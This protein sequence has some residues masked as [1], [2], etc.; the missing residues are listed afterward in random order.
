MAYVISNI[1]GAETN[2][3]DE[4]ESWTGT[5]TVEAGGVGGNYFYRIT[6]TANYIKLGVKSAGGGISQNSFGLWFRSSTA[7]PAALTR[8]LQF[9]NSGGTAQCYLQIKTDGKI[10]LSDASANVTTSQSAITVDTWHFIEVA[11]TG[12]LATIFLD[13]VQGTTPGSWSATAID[14]CFLQA[15]TGSYTFDFDNLFF[16]TGTTALSDRLGGSEIISYR[17]NLN[18]ATPDTGTVLNTGTWLQAQQ[19]PFNETPT[20]AYTGS[21]T[22]AGS[23]LTNDVGG[24]AGTGGPSTDTNIT[25]SILAA[26]GVW[27]A[28]RGGGSTTSHYG[29]LGNSADDTTP[30]ANLGLTTLIKNYY[31]LSELSTIVPIASEVGKIGIE[32]NTGGQ[33]FLLADMLFT[34]LHVPAVPI[35]V[36]PS[37]LEATA[38]V[39]SVT[40]AVFQTVL[41]T[42]LGATAGVGNVTVI[43]GAGQTVIPGPEEINT[44]YFDASDEGPTDTSEDWTDD[45]NAFDGSTATA[46]TTIE[47]G[48]LGLD[49][50]GTT[51]PTSGDVILGVKARHYGSVIAGGGVQLETKIYTNG[52]AELLGTY[53]EA[54]TYSPSWRSYFQLAVPS[55]GWT[56]QKANDLEVNLFADVDGGGTATISKVEID[57]TSKGAL[58]IGATGEVG[59]VTVDIAAGAVNV[60]VSGV[61]STG[62]VGSVTVGAGANISAAPPLQLGYFDASISGPTDAEGNWSN[63]A[64]AFDND[65]GTSA[66]GVLPATGRLVG[67][68]NTLGTLP[69]VN[70]EVEWRFHGKVNTNGS[71][72]TL[73]L[74]YDNGTTQIVAA[75]QFIQGNTPIWTSWV[76]IP[77]P[78]G[79]WSQS[80][81]D[82][83]EIRYGIQEG[84]GTFVDSDV[85]TTEIRILNELKGTG[86]VGTPTVVAEANID[87]SGNEATAAV[88]TSSV[89][90]DSNVIPIGIAVTSEVESVAVEA[91]ANTSVLGLAA[92][93]AVSAVSVGISVLVAVVGLAATASVGSVEASGEAVVSV[94]GV[95]ATSAVGAVT[96]DEGSAPI[97]VPVTGVGST[98]QVGSVV[99]I[100]GADVSVSGV[101]VTSETGSVI[102]TG[103]ALVTVSGLGAASG[104]GSVSVIAGTSVVVELNGRSVT[105]SVGSASITG[106]AIVLASG[107]EATAEVGTVTISAASDISVLGIE[108]TADVGSVSVTGKAVVIPAG[109]V[110]TTAIGAVTIIAGND[111]TVGVSGVQGTGQVG[112]VAIIGDAVIPVSG[113]SATGEVDSVTVALPRVAL[114]TGV[115]ATSG[116]SPVTVIG[117]A[118]VTPDGVEATAQIG[119]VTATGKAN[120][121]LILDGVE[122]TGEVGTV[123]VIGD[124]N[125]LVTG[126]EATSEV[127]LVTIGF[128][129]SVTGVEATGEVGLVSVTG[130]ANVLLTGIEAT[131]GVGAVIVQTGSGIIVIPAGIEVT[132]EVGLVTVSGIAIVIETGLEVTAEVGSVS[133]LADANIALTGIEVD[134]EVGSVTVST[135][136]NVTVL[137]AGVSSTGSVG[138]A[139][140]IGDANIQLSGVDAVS[141]IGSVTVLIDGSVDVPL[142]GVSGTGGVGLVAVVADAN[143]LLA[144][145]EG[146]GETGSV[147]VVVNVGVSITGVEATGN[148]GSVSTS[149]QGS[150]LVTLGQWSDSYYYN[151][152]TV[153]SQ[154]NWT[155]PLNAMDGSITTYAEIVSPYENEYLELGYGT[156]A[157]DLGDTIYEVQARAYGVLNT[158]DIAQSFT[159]RF[160]R[161][162]NWDGYIIFAYP[163]GL[164][165]T[166]WNTA[167]QSKTIRP[168]TWDDVVNQTKITAVVNEGFGPPWEEARL[169]RAEIR[170]LH[171]DGSGWGLETTG[172]VGSVVVQTEASV[173]VIVSGVEAVGQVGTA[174]FT[175]DLASTMPGTLIWREP[176]VESY[177]FTDNKFIQL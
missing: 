120:V 83:L 173:I 34:I 11:Y 87:S 91:K 46:A 56:W 105:G 174:R 74:I 152:S 89:A 65:T 159:V 19:L 118:L 147:A 63:D 176:E 112:S 43:E 115:E 39:D 133:V 21:G 150:I 47:W 130:D 158:F 60:P 90:G 32:R 42:G 40:V 123:A 114:A 30:S 126:V 151:G 9:K 107:V 88:G 163:F 127:G 139:S 117:D 7:A 17:S 6:G 111:I 12:T 70:S 132:G 142:T 37:G 146:T 168:W 82:N 67:K 52:K 33:N 164:G 155:N 50:G 72:K 92:A 106:Y 10:E 27:W 128:S 154:G 110:G 101:E 96:V 144:G 24:S 153:I 80:E 2:G 121:I 113:V 109:V 64:N 69:D 157:T 169:Y 98:G 84:S 49:A 1:F 23:V 166:N 4:V 145:I 170:V 57:V 129:V 44:Y 85:Y 172:E 141:G 38:S 31:F 136:G 61:A 45:A 86:Q 171:G 143:I 14:D 51:A 104:V 95:E 77:P 62:Q 66:T 81:L 18:S 162:T 58:D 138:S 73:G 140:V 161:R 156:N 13:G 29:L 59:S 119:L 22:K 149:G 175:E 108:V 116:L 8:V 102:V 125:I 167:A 15:D 76:T 165:W 5:P 78:G 79:T 28:K 54:A 97:D 3:F 134:G 55:G 75:N 20:I 16:L 93:A 131:S 68:G 41:P 137:V 48:S 36:T 99:V 35:T 122:A 25:G 94:A 148:F 103:K 160:A 135:A 177:V 124:A 100:A 26:K 53:N 71:G